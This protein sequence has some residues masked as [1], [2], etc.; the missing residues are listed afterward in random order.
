MCVSKD[1][2]KAAMPHTKA[3]AI[4]NCYSPLV[5][6]VL[7]CDTS[8]RYIEIEHERVLGSFFF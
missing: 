1:V 4:A 5:L 8:H 7:K 3:M 6:H 2:S